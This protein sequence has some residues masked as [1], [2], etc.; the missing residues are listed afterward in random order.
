MST[1][2]QRPPKFRISRKAA[3]CLSGA[4]L[5]LVLAFLGGLLARPYVKDDR[6]LQNFARYVMGY[7]LH[8]QRLNEA[9]V[10]DT[11]AATDFSALIRV[12]DGADVAEKRRQLAQVIWRNAQSPFGRQPDAV[13]DGPLLPFA[14]I[15]SIRQVQRLRVDM[16]L[17]VTS[18]IFVL[19]P[20]APRSC[21]MLYQEGHRVSFL[22]RKS[23]LRRLVDSGCT[24]AALSYPLT[25]GVNSRP[26]IDLPRLGR[27]LLN[28]P[29]KLELLET[30]E[31]STLQFFLTPPMVALNHLL[32]QQS[33]TLVGMAGFSGGGWVTTMVA[34]LDP[35]IQT[36]Y[37]VAGS[38]PLAVHAAAPAWG[39]YEQT[40]PR[41]YTIAT[42]PELYVMAAAGPGRRH[43]QFY[44][45][46]DPC[47]FS[48]ENWRHWRN[49]VAERAAAL[50]GGFDILTYRHPEHTLG[51]EVRDRIVA[52]FTN[53]NA[54]LRDKGPAPR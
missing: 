25:G 23:L 11:V 32:A 42:Y 46:D 18:E 47:C 30:E 52:D 39:S 34:A 14:D 16:P 1:K 3:F 50:G 6:I 28:D 44:N 22:E 5:S 37:S 19:T 48:G 10:F 26:E 7:P 8:K 15:A 4:I 38:A 2:A 31:F 43:W 49:P 54:T 35:R 40:L 33:F 9:R 27:I 51:R 41:L 17:G 13:L 45:L 21:L 24:V 29:D 36:S 53:Q 12:R 20:K